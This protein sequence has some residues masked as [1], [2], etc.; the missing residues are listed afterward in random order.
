MLSTYSQRSFR[1]N[2]NLLTLSYLILLYP[3]TQLLRY[4]SPLQIRKLRLTA[5]NQKVLVREG[6]KIESIPDP[7]S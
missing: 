3:S 2:K 7:T 6:E 1:N 5:T 4:I